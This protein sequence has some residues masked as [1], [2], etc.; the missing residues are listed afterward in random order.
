M[1]K[2]LYIAL[3]LF[4]GYGCLDEN[5]EPDEFTYYDSADL[6]S[7]LEITNYS[8]FRDRNSFL[9]SADE[10]YENLGNYYLIDIRNGEEYSRGHV[11][12]AVSVLMN[13]LID[14]FESI[15]S[16]TFDKIVVI[17]QTGQRSA[18]AVSLLRLYGYDNVYSLDFGMGQWNTEFS[19]EWID[20]R[21]DSRYVSQLYLQNN[22]KPPLTKE[23]P[24]IY[25]EE[26]KLS[27][28]SLLKYRIAECLTETKYAESLSNIEELESSYNL[29][30]KKFENAFIICYGEEA[31][32]GIQQI[33]KDIL[34]E[35][36]IYGGHPRHSVR[37]NSME[38]FRSSRYLLS[39]PVN[40]KIFIY[41]YNGQES[42]YLNAFLTLLGYES[43]NIKFGA[44]SMFYYY[45]EFGDFTESFKVNE[46]RNYPIAK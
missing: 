9:I 34:P 37:F 25:S 15:K 29:I 26:S 13:E 10:V 27:V 24:K 8:Y 39:M 32:Y 1:K 45:M 11:Q 36:L 16:S 18:Y 42:S 41:S 3:I 22:P 4:S 21:K 44:V 28:D 23:L 40:S 5:T 19:S 17:S 46:I 31:L 35:P 6:V 20:A 38:E 14:H 7:F 12:G 2:L 43:R 30:H 33:N